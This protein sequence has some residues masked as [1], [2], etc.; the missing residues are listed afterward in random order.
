MK[1]THLQLT[2][3]LL[4]PDITPMSYSVHK[5]QDM[6]IEN[7]FLVVRSKVF[8]RLTKSRV[9]QFYAEHE[10]KF[11]FNRLVTFMSSGPVHAYVLARE[12]GIQHWRS[13]MGPTKVFKTRLVNVSLS[14]NLA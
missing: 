12:D 1:K 5:I 3:A 2:L 13:L 11:F 6:I 8:P 14:Q 10:G 7:D 4:K 9:R